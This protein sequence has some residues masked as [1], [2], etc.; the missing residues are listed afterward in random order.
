MS[1]RD[2]VALYIQEFLEWGLIP[3][4]TNIECAK[5]EVLLATNRQLNHC[6]FIDRNLIIYKIRFPTWI[7]CS[8]FGP[9]I[10]AMLFGDFNFDQYRFF[11]TTKIVYLH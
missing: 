3:F 6:E 8:I 10:D 1:K 11:W 4:E 2:I 7:L 9:K 5:V